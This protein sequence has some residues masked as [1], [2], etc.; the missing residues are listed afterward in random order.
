[1]ALSR[2]PSAI[3]PGPDGSKPL[4]YPLLV[5]PV[6]DRKCVSCHSRV[7][8]EGK[9][10]LTGEPEGRYTVSYNALV[11]RVAVSAWW[12]NSAPNLYK[13]REPL[14]MPDEFGARG[15]AIMQKLLAGHEN[16]VLTAEEIER[17]ATW[18][19]ANGLF[20]GTFDVADQA[21]QQ[22]AQR[23]PGPALE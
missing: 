13:N 14:T 21:R 10:V 12:G 2:E 20:Y 11:K 9:V 22:R 8:P 5:Q 18:M 19:D 17:L 1:L 4:S 7:K 16:V 15:S 3:R 23:I 6:L